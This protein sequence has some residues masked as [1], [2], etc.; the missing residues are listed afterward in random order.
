MLNST[1]GRARKGAMSKH[2]RAIDSAGTL[3]S[4]GVHEV[5]SVLFLRGSP[6]AKALDWAQTAA[7][8][9]FFRLPQKTFTQHIETAK[10]NA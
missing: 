4:S 2:N 5:G 8:Y 10:I 7:S 6:F 1:V 3:N 9:S